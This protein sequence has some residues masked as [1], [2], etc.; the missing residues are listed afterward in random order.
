[1]HQ[2]L[3]AVYR[4]FISCVRFLLDFFLGKEGQYLWGEVFCEIGGCSFCRREGVEG[5]FSSF[6]FR[7]SHKANRNAFI[8]LRAS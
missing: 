5:S 7:D 6:L 1:M 4:Y 3:L 8:K 2:L